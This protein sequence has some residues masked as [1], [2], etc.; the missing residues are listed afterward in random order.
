M[1]KHYAAH[2]STVNLLLYCWRLN[3]VYSTKET[4]LP[5]ASELLEDNE[6]ISPRF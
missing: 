3:S 4:L 2:I 6:D 1:F 5:D